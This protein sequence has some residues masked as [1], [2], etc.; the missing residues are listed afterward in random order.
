MSSPRIVISAGD[1]IVA[2]QVHVV[3][4]PGEAGLVNEVEAEEGDEVNRKCRRWLLV[5]LVV[6]VQFNVSVTFTLLLWLYSQLC[7]F[8]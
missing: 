8:P 6:L 4:H 7:S 5:F 3:D 2:Q 1:L